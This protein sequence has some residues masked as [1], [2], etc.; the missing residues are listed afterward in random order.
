M[1]NQVSLVTED[2][3]S[4]HLKDVTNL[5]NNVASYIP[6]LF[7][8]PVTKVFLDAAKIADN[9]EENQKQCNELLKL[10]VSSLETLESKL[11][12]G[13]KPGVDTTKIDT[14]HYVKVLNDITD[15]MNKLAQPTALQ[16][17]WRL[18]TSDQVLIT[19]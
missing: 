1:S 17:I 15:Y 4:K 11:A 5:L 18:V 8:G 7:A 3:H 13:I 6:G 19:F 14:E 9:T 16:K 2:Y 10:I 12:S